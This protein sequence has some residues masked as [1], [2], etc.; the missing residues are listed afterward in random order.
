MYNE[1]DCLAD[2]VPELC[3]FA[4]ENQFDLIFIND[5][6]TD[7]TSELLQ[8]HCTSGR[9]LHHKVNQGY[10]GAIKTGIRAATSCYVVTVDADGQHQPEDILTLLHLAEEKNADMVVGARPGD[11]GSSY[12]RLGKQIIR[13]IAK[14]LI[15]LKIEDINSGMKLYNRELAVS[16]LHMLPDTMA[17]S[18]IIL[19]TFIHQRHLIVEHPIK[20]RERRA[21]KSTINMGTAF[22]T[23]YEIISVVMLFNPV[24]IFL[25]FSFFLFILGAGWSFRFLLAGRG[26]PVAS[27]ILIISSAL[28]MLMGLLAQQISELRKNMSCR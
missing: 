11:K 1:E 6:S 15:P 17:F 19:F 7:R 24:K 4:E 22:Q 3:R 8:T 20:V 25:P 13:S 21:G 23:M 9:V 26:F 18:E 28:T 10:G 12:R 2:T 16:T 14:L 5:G 27:S